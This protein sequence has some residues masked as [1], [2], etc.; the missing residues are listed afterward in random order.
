M[1]SSDR[2]QEE[3]KMAEPPHSPDTRAP[4]IPRW[5][6]LF[7]V[8]AAL[9][10]LLFVVLLLAG[11]HGPQRHGKSPPTRD[12]IALFAAPT[13]AVGRPDAARLA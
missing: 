5:V 6:K 10:V 8:V 4:G 9:V 12:L 3:A 7:G 13:P 11:G 2:A 1:S